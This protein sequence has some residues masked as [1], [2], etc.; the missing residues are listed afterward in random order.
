[1]KRPITKE[2]HFTK[3]ILLGL[4]FIL[5]VDQL[6][7]QNPFFKDYSKTW[8]TKMFLSKPDGKGGC[9]INLT[10]EQALKVIKEADNLSLGVPKIIYL[11][12]W[13]YLGHD[14]KYPAFFEVNNLLK[15]DED[16]SGIESL[17]WLIREAKKYHTTISL[18][19]NMTDA[20]DDSPLWKEYVEKDLISK[21]QDG[22]L[23]MIGEYNGRKAYQINYRNE[24]EAGITQWRIDRLME[25][26]PELREAGTIHCDAWIA[27]DSEGHRET[28][29]TEALYQQKAAL[30][31]RAKGVDITTEWVMDYMMGYVPLY[32]HF[33]G[34]SQ[35]DYLKYPA[36]ICCG[37]GLNPD[38]KKSD[39]G[40]GFLF[41]ES[42]Y[43][44][45]FWGNENWTK[46]RSIKND[47][48]LKFPQFYFLN[49]FE[50]LSVEGS[51]DNRVANYSDGVKVSLADQTIT[52]WGRIIRKGNTLFI[53][54]LWREDR[55]V[56]AYSSTSGKK[57]FDIPFNWAGVE[58]VSIQKITSDGLSLIA[59]KKISENQLS[60]YLEQE[61][62]YYVVPL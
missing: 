26:L 20:Y 33:N 46:G 60:F 31:W 44:E 59:V 14:D 28:I 9:Q 53:P 49:H 38:L 5:M 61:T 13:Q 21:N 34:Y 40:L 52:Q 11:V 19:I 43:G 57:V 18:H 36:S 16:S 25:L 50:R 1:M 58:K 27:R 54:A 3:K 39:F 30:Y 23:K 55:G 29:V 6:Y 35:N 47:F 51:G 4:L 32:W 62:P 17:R 45:P 10:F 2:K 37:V 56:I 42:C 48:F 8:T 22:S 7:A 15:R 41:G 24:W 12:G